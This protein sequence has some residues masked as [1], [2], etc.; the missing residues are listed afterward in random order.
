M[1]TADY[2][3]EVSEAARIFALHSDC[4][5]WMDDDHYCRRCEEAARFIPLIKARDLRIRAAARRGAFEE[6][7]KLFKGPTSYRKK[8]LLLMARS[9]VPTP[10]SESKGGLKP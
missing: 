9:S 1:T 4:P 2:E 7:A 5:H 10:E 3:A 8:Q 6:A